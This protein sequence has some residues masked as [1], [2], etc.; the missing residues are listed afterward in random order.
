MW[1]T[2][3]LLA[4]LV[5]VSCSPPEPW[6]ADARQVIR[7]HEGFQGHPYPDAGGWSV[8]YGHTI[9]L[10]SD[11]RAGRTA[12]LADPKWR[13]SLYLEE[14]FNSDFESAVTDARHFVNLA[15]VFIDDVEDMV[16]ADGKRADLFAT[17]PH[18]VQVALIDM[19]YELG[20][21]T[22]LLGFEDFRRSIAL[23]RWADAATDLERSR[24]CG[25]VPQRCRNAITRIAN[26]Q[27]EASP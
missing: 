9:L 6:V 1:H 5:L 10:P 19:A 17:L 11:V 4:L 2:R 7:E 21:P 25:R 13:D 18:G 12:T 14:L 15:S 8:G 27:E 22:G 24:W 20:G 26:S 16:G 23:G 3:L